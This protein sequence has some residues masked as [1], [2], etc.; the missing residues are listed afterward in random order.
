[1]E[2]KAEDLGIKRKFS[3]LV[4]IG[5]NRIKAFNVGYRALGVG[6]DGIRVGLV[7]DGICGFNRRGPNLLGSKRS[8]RLW[9]IAVV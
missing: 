9:L 2:F 4:V 1:M 7:R 8:G 3:Q 6:F 5:E